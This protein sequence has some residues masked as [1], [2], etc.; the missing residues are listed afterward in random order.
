MLS[1]TALETMYCVMF[2]QSVHIA[3]YSNVNKMLTACILKFSGPYSAFIFIKRDVC[4]VGCTNKEVNCNFLRRK[5]DSAMKAYIYIYICTLTPTFILQTR[6]FIQ[7]FISNAIMS[8]V[9]CFS[10]FS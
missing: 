10:K 5:L 7:F 6:E 9:K 4:V 3:S 8:N 2:M 1:N